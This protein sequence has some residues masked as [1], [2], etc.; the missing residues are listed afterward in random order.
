MTNRAP[1][2]PG[3]TV[4][5]GW[6]LMGK[7][8]DS[9]SD[10]AVLRSSGGFFSR[11]GFDEILRRFTP[12]TPSSGSI[13]EA[14]PDALPWVTVSYAPRGGSSVLGIAERTWSDQRDGA[15]RLIA[16]TSYLCVPFPD[17][18]GTPVSYATL[19][20]T[21]SKANIAKRNDGDEPLRIALTPLD[22][23]ELAEH[24][25]RFGFQLVATTAALLLA[26]R[27]S[28]CGG[29][30][31]SPNERTMLRLRF[32]DAV[33]ALL[34]YG[35]RSKLVA[36]TWADGGST[37]R[38]RLAF[39]NRP[40]PGHAAVH[41]P[42]P[43]RPLSPA[44]PLDGRCADY[45]DLLT[46]MKKSGRTVSEIV[47]HLASAVEPHRTNDPEHAIRRLGRL[48]SRV[49]IAQAIH[50]G[51]ARAEE[52]RELLR[53]GKISQ[54]DLNL[55]LEAVRLLLQAAD[56]E[57][58]ETVRA[59]W[60]QWMAVDPDVEELDGWLAD[61][62]RALGREHLWAGPADLATLNRLLDLAD[63]R[64]F[65]GQVLA[66]LLDAGAARNEL[67]RPRR[68]QKTRRAEPLTDIPG[69]FQA[70]EQ[71]RYTTAASL[72]VE[73]FLSGRLL[74]GSATASTDE[75]LLATI[76]RNVF[77]RLPLELIRQLTESSEETTDKPVRVLLGWLETSSPLRGVLRPFRDA[78]DGTPGPKTIP[79]ADEHD[80]QGHT[81]VLTL[82]QLACWAG[83]EPTRGLLPYMLPW[84]LRTAPRLLWR[85]D[86]PAWIRA[87]D[88]ATGDPLEA[89]E[90]GAVHD[91][92]H[93]A[94]HKAAHRAAADLLLLMF[95]VQ[96]H[97]PPYLRVA[98]S[99]ASAEAYVSSFSE[100]FAELH[101]RETLGGRRNRQLPEQVVLRLVTYIEHTGWPRSP[102][103]VEPLL[104]L[105]LDVVEIC[106]D[107]DGGPAAVTLNSGQIAAAQA[108]RELLDSQPDLTTLTSAAAWLT[109]IQ[110]N[111]PDL[112]RDSGLD[113]T[114][115]RRPRLGF[116]TG[117]DRR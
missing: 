77:T 79:M 70:S 113:R 6:A 47:E 106:D 107:V 51:T 22:P 69:P 31:G 73:R 114:A 3:P 65:A 36:S 84:L 52:V 24:I 75:Q 91:T 45:F 103:S 29:P 10:Y 99:T 33:A 57:D 109:W 63:D 15:R 115:R 102:H 38:I 40:R 89:D 48:D 2:D 82:L 35:Q 41:W 37:H 19:H 17:L 61:T 112:L 58:V 101:R 18:A 9:D 32:L 111:C 16:T 95:N 64:G 53:A 25:E 81:Y 34:P 5:A 104:G 110:R 4:P 56:T 98:G 46:T 74:T 108:V 97:R 72:V 92:A 26:H 76:T 105:L 49:H 71:Q 60:P 13:R 11:A 12:G 8:P 117:R 78:L 39:T 28:V 86:R 14:L 55:R 90:H 93:D 20:S 23:D 59:V 43:G 116:R 88:R 1:R 62:V 7:E 80:K 87:L 94:A 30:T 68:R 50:D 96:P 67:H 83:P 44:P 42:S 66:A 27:V 85:K 21:L 100:K 54:S